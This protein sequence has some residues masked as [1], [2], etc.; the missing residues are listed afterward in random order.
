M[1]ASMEMAKDHEERQLQRRGV[2]DLWGRSWKSEMIVRLKDDH[3]R[4]LSIHASMLER[5]EGM[6]AGLLSEEWAATVQS[7]ERIAKLVGAE[8][9]LM[10]TLALHPTRPK[11]L[12]QTRPGKRGGPVEEA[13][14]VISSNPDGIP[15]HAGVSPSPAEPIPTDSGPCPVETQ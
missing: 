7:A 4:L 3:T 2:A 12:A 1:T 6:P 11:G 14:L 5:L 8:R 9:E 10:L 13:T 15:P